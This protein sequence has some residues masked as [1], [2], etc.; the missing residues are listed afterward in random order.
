M[1]EASRTDEFENE[2]K[3]TPPISSPI[4]TLTSTPIWL[5]RA[6][7][8]SALVYIL[9]LTAYLIFIIVC[10]ALYPRCEPAPQT[11]WWINSVFLRFSTR[12][13]TWND[14]NEK[15]GQYQNNFCLV[16]TKIMVVTRR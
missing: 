8:I 12:S 5:K 15:L 16:Y 14:V 3:V 10:I 2:S 7:I 11:P 6:R 1:I 4:K 9:L 13:L